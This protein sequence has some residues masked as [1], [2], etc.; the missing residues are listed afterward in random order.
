MSALSSRNI[1]LHYNWHSI[2]PKLASE[3]IKVAYKDKGK[4]IFSFKIHTL[5]NCLI[6]VL[7]KIEVQ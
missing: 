1:S 2:A 7:D 5:I 4:G 3:L 6:V